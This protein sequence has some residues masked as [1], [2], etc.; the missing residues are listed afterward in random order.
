MIY[1]KDRVLYLIL[2][3]EANESQGTV[4]ILRIYHGAR[5]TG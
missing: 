3:P 1:G 2:E 4:E 5:Y